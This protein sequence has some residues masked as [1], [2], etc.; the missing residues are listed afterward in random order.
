[1]KPSGIKSIY[2][3][4]EIQ[5][6]EIF[7][8]NLCRIPLGQVGDLLVDTLDLHLGNRPGVLH[9][10]QPVVEDNLELVEEDNLEPVEEDNLAGDNLQGTAGAEPR[11]DRGSLDPQELQL[12][13]GPLLRSSGGSWGC[14]HLGPLAER[15]QGIQL[16]LHWGN[17]I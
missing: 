3:S 1:M 8:F 13:E 16:V 15:S 2:Q 17:L 7:S 10:L 9:N 5:F 14:G 12:V 4:S 11:T 6:S